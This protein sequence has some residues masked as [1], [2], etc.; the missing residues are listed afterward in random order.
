DG[1]GDTG[2]LIADVQPLNP[3]DSSQVVVYGEIYD[4]TTANG[5]RLYV[6]PAG[7]GFR[8]ATDY[9]AAPPHTFSAGVNGY[10]I[11]PLTWDSSG[12]KV[13]RGRGSRNGIEGT[14]APLPQA[15]T[16]SLTSFPLSFARRVDVPLASPADS[17]SVD[18]L[19]S[20]SWAA[21]PGAA[22]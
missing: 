3:A 22:R 17:A 12:D 9:V 20:L 19:P 4:G 1:L 6:D 15:A 11:R 21:V 2:Y 14:A 16:V 10:K 8:P 13:F 7:Q 5:Y 18:S